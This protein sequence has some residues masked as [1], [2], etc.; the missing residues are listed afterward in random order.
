MSQN[1]PLNFTVVTAVALLCALS[2]QST[3]ETAERAL[4]ST[5]KSNTPTT[6]QTCSVNQPSTLDDYQRLDHE[7]YLDLPD[8]IISRATAPLE[9]SFTTKLVQGSIAAP[10]S[11]TFCQISVTRLVVDVTY[12][13]LDDAISHT[14][15]RAIYRW[16]ASNDLAGWQIAELGEKFHCA[17]ERHQ[18]TSRCL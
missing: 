16:V 15:T 5:L 14:T 6:I 7:Q 8:P 12:A 9:E 17:R 11:K 4:V 2:A 1:S 18:R 10:L 13:T 3:A